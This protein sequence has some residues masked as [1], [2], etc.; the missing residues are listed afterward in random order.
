MA[1][2]AAE[3]AGI[4]INDISVLTMGIAAGLMAI[5][6]MLLWLDKE[7]SQD[8]LAGLIMRTIIIGCQDQ[9][10]KRTKKKWGVLG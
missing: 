3:Q 1:V 10:P 4:A 7:L 9:N 8:E 2:A 6:L 5:P